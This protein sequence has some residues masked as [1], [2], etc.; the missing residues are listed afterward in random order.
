MEWIEIENNWNEFKWIVKEHWTDLNEKQLALTAGNR[1]RIARMIQ[2]SYQLT[3]TEAEQQLSEWQDAQINID[4]HFYHAATT[5][6]TY[7]R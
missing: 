3:A 2:R 6:N 5:N 1:E 4:G 7:V